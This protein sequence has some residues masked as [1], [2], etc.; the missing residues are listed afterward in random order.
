MI[1]GASIPSGFLAKYN[2]DGICQ[3][4]EKLDIHIGLV[5]A[6]KRSLPIAVSPE[7]NIYCASFYGGDTL[8][9]NNGIYATHKINYLNDLYSFIAKFNSDGLCQWA[10]DL[11]GPPSVNTIS[12]DKRQNIILGGDF[13]SESIE[14][15]NGSKLIKTDSAIA[16]LFVALCDSN[17]KCKWAN[18][19]NG[20]GQKY[21]SQPYYDDLN[22]VIADNN[23]N[24]YITGYIY[25][26]SLF[27]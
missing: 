1:G 11:M 5:D 21:Q 4:A 10:E 20:T 13:S 8:K 25:S 3:W 16:N 17:G 12:I 22:E 9:F 6:L 26:D 2:T 19:I 15:N 24:V 23:G 27:F 14:F 18:R 7:G